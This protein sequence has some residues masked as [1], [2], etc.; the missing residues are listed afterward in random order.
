MWGHQSPLE[1]RWD[2][3][4]R[5]APPTP[6][7]RL[8]AQSTIRTTARLTFTRTRTFMAAGVGEADGATAIAAAMVMVGAARSEAA[9]FM[10]VAQ[11]VAAVGSTPAV[12]DFMAAEA[13]G[14]ADNR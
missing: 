5:L 2:L 10:A 14:A 6:T 9:G 11:S 8:I 3:E 4:F 13:M 7:T 12:V 1:L